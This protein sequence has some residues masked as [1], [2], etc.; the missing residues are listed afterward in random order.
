M[1]STSRPNSSGA[2]TNTSSGRASGKLVRV[3]VKRSAASKE[4]PPD[5]SGAPR[6]T[7]EPLDGRPNLD[8]TD[9]EGAVD[10]DALKTALLAAQADATVSREGLHRMLRAVQRKPFLEDSESVSREGKVA[11]SAAISARSSGEASPIFGDSD[12]RF[13]TMNDGR[14]RDQKLSEREREERWKEMK[15]LKDTHKQWRQSCSFSFPCCDG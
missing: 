6:G 11:H 9:D 7:A 14:V 8:P 1:L 10:P 13:M 12:R 3:G 4:G 5:I 2:R 15:S